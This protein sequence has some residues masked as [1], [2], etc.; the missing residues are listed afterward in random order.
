[1]TTRCEGNRP[2]SHEGEQTVDEVKWKVD[3]LPADMR[4]VMTLYAGCIEGPRVTYG[5]V[6]NDRAVLASGS[7]EKIAK[8][9][10][11]EIVEID[12]KSYQRNIG[13]KQEDTVARLKDEM[14]GTG[15]F[16]G[17]GHGGYTIT[18]NGQL[19]SGDSVLNRYFERQTAMKGDKPIVKDGKNVEYFG[20]VE[21]I[22]SAI[23]KPGS[24]ESKF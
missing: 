24:L 16:A 19:V 7:A 4:V 14:T 20:G 11:G 8:Y 22:V 15:E 23:I 10:I 9:S 17:K 1:M 2:T 18:V 6:G 12:G 3:D 13:R 5:A 21:M